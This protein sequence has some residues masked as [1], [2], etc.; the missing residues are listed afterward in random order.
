M[1][2]FELMQYTQKFLRKFFGDLAG[3]KV[4]YN[5]KDLNRINF[6][7]NIEPGR[8][9]G[10]IYFNANLTPKDVRNILFS[11]KRKVVDSLSKKEK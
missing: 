10:S 7:I 2:K 4:T 9:I 8:F 3:I 5:T 11:F 1:N 6:T